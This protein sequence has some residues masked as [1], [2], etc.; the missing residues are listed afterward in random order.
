[1]PFCQ[2]TI[3]YML[4]GAFYFETLIVPVELIG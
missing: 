2:L 1:M 3:T 4:T